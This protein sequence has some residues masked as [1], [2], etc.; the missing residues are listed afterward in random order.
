MTFK[1]GQKYDQIRRLHMN[2]AQ[3]KDR[4][5]ALKSR[6]GKEFEVLLN[7]DNGTLYIREKGDMA[8]APQG[9]DVVVVYRTEGCDET[10]KPTGD[11]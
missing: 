3:A 9:S 6:Y 4:A 10:F 7:E 5:N 1:Y 11:G 8:L 2:V